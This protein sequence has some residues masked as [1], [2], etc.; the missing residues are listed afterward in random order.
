M[1]IIKLPIAFYGL[2]RVLIDINS[3]NNM[4]LSIIIQTPQIKQFR[5]S[6]D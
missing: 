6:E 3:L 2:R 4:E 5:F 1:Y